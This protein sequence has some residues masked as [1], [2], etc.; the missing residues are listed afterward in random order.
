MIVLY[1]GQQKGSAG[2][3]PQT[4]NDDLSN[5][6]SFA[7]R[8]FIWSARVR[9]SLVDCS[10]AKWIVLRAAL[11]HIALHSLIRNV[12]NT[13]KFTG[14]TLNELSSKITCKFLNMLWRRKF[15]FLALV[16]TPFQVYN[17]NRNNSFHTGND[18]FGCK[19]RGL[20]VPKRNIS[21]VFN[22]NPL[23]L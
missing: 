3:R 23:F 17:L 11:V 22:E 13:T 12:K 9:C 10:L 19:Q 14:W 16:R 20:Q 15:K 6:P 18:N 7:T 4:S 21:L 2:A 1:V 8:H 5:T